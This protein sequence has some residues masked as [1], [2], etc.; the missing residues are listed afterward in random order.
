MVLTV[1]YKFIQVDGLINKY[2]INSFCLKECLITSEGRGK[3]GII[4]S[5]NEKKIIKADVISM[6]NLGLTS[7]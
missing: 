7:K 3:D 6:V 5:K 1:V 2:L 4:E